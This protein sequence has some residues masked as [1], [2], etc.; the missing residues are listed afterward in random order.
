MGMRD[1]VAL[2]FVVAAVVVTV[3]LGS[4]VAYQFAHAPTLRTGVAVAVPGAAG[5]ATSGGEPGDAALPPTGATGP[6]AGS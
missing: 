1:R 2:V 5:P 4:M 6:A 3:G